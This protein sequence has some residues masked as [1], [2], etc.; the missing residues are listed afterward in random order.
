[1]SAFIDEVSAELDKKTLFNIYNIATSEPIP[2]INVK[3]AAKGK[4]YMSYHIFVK[5]LNLIE[6]IQI[7]KISKKVF[8]SIATANYI[9]F[10]SRG[11]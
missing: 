10:R 7:I 6:K 8:L 9:Y 2:F 3:L 11:E 1:M 4:N 5:K